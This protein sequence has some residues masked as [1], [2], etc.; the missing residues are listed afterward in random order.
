MFPLLEG[1]ACF[2]EQHIHPIAVQEE[3]TMRGAICNSTAAV[4]P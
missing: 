1:D 2:V 3:H 4:A